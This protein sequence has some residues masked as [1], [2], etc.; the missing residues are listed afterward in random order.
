VLATSV[1]NA[2]HCVFADAAG[3]V[4]ICD[5]ND[6]RLLRETPASGGT[7]SESV[8]DAKL[9][10]PS[11]IAEDA[12]GNLYVADTNNKLIFKETLS[13]ST[14]TQST[15]ATGALWYPTSVA[16]DSS[17]NLY[18]GNVGMN[19]LLKET[20]AGR[21]YT[22]TVIA[23]TGLNYPDSVVLDST[24]AL[25]IVDTYNHRVVRQQLYGDELGA[26][27]VGSTATGLVSSMV[28]TFDSGGS[29][30]ATP[31]VTR[32][33]LAGSDFAMLPSTTCVA[34][35]S[36]NTGDSCTVDV[37]FTPTIAGSVNGS[38]VIQG[39]SG[40]VIATGYVHGTGVAPQVSFSP[41]VES[42][43]GSGFKNPRAVAA[44]ASGNVYIADTDNQRIVKETIA[45]GVYTQSVVSTSALQ[46]P[47]GVAVDGSGNVYVSDTYH[48]REL[49]ETI[50]PCAHGAT[51]VTT[52]SVI[53]SK[54]LN[55]P[56]GIAVD[57]AGVFY[58]A[59]S[60]NN[61]VL[62]ET[63][64][65]SG[66]VA[67][68]LSFQGLTNLYGIAVDGAGNLYL[69]DSGNNRI[70]KETYAGGSYTQSVIPTSTLAFPR[71]VAVDANGD[72]FIADTN[73]GR[74]IEEALLNGS[75][76]ESVV[77]SGL[78]SPDS[79]A[80][81]GSGNLYITDTA[82]NAVL[83][84]TFAAPPALQF[85][86][87]AVGSASPLQMVTLTNVGNAPLSFPAPSAGTNPAL[88]QG[89]TFDATQTNSCPSTSAGHD[90][91]A[92]LPAGQSCVLALG[93]APTTAADGQG[94]AVLSDTNLNVPGG[95]QTIP[96]TGT[97][98]AD[99]VQLLLQV[100]ASVTY[101]DAVQVVAQLTN[102]SSTDS[103]A[104]SVLF[105]DQTASFGTQTVAH[106]QAAQSYLASSVGQV[107]LNASFT[108]QD[109]TLN[110][111]KGNATLTVLAAPLNVAATDASRTYGG[112]NPAFAGTVSGAVNGDSFKESF[113]TSATT[114]S[115]VA[116]YAITPSVSGTGLANYQQTIQA[117]TL[118]VTAAS[119][120]VI[121]NNALRSYGAANPNFTGSVQGAVN[122]DTFTETFT[123]PATASSA[124][125]S[126]AIAPTAVGPSLANYTQTPQNGTLTVAAA[127]LTASANDATRAYGASNP[128]FT[129]AVTGAVNGDVLTESF[130]TTAAAS[131]P[132]GSY[133]IVP[134]VGGAAIGNYTPVLKNG[135]LTVT[136]AALRVVANNTVRSYGATNPTFTGSVQGAVNGDTFTE[137]FT[138]PA[139]ATSAPGSYAIAPAAVGPALANYTQSTE[140]GTLTVKAAALTASA[141]DVTRAYGAAN[142]VFTGAVSGA[143]NGDVV[144]ESFTTTAAASSPAGSY[145]IV[146]AISGAAAGNYT[147]VLK[148]GT[149]TV[150]GAAL[151]ASANDVTRAYGA[152]NPAFTGAVT[153]AVNGDV[154]TESFRTTAAVSSPAGSYAIVPAV[155][156]AAIGNYTPV[157]KNGALT[158]TAAALTA[159]A[160]DVTRAYGAANPVFTGA[161]TGAM[162]GDVLTE[163]FSTSA[164]T[165]SP[166]GSYAIVPAL[167]GAAAGNYTPVLK[168]GTLTVTAAAL[169][170]SAHDA[171]RAYGAV[172]PVFTGA[173]TGA[174]NGEVFTESFTTT[175]NAQSAP[176][177]YGITPVAAGAGL[178]NY[179]QTVVPGTLTITPAALTVSAVNQTLAYGQANPVF[180]G[181]VSGAAAP[182]SFT[183][184]FATERTAGSPVGRYAIVPTAVGPALGVYAVTVQPGQITVTP[185]ALTVAANSVSRSYGAANPV[186]TGQVQGVVNG[187][188][189]TATYTT[190]ATA[191][192][193]AGSYPIH[194]VVTG[195]ALGNYTVAAVDGVLSVNAVS[196]TTALTQPQGGAGTAGP[197]TLQAGV[198]PSAGETVTPTGNVRFYQG[199]TMLAEVPLV[200]GAAS[201][202]GTLPDVQTASSLTAVYQGDGNCLPSS[203]NAIEESVNTAGFWMKL[204][205]A[206]V[207][208][209]QAASTSASVQT[210]FPLQVGPGASGV[211][212]GVVTFSVQ[213]LPAGA[214]ATFSP[215]TLQANSG[216]QNVSMQVT[217]PETATAT[218]A[219]SGLDSGL[220]TNPTRG[221]GGGSAASRLGGAVLAL[222]LLPLAG[223][224]RLRAAGRGMK[225]VCL[226]LAGCAAVAGLTGCG[227]VMGP[228]MKVN[229]A[230]QTVSYH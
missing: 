81:D 94:Y 39:S 153:G 29:L 91:G 127:S 18:I 47:L 148:N 176:G 193:P 22:Q 8:V 59:D 33:G 209:A 115:P 174:V 166:A 207:Q 181:Q 123:T 204:H 30:A 177:S 169:T 92:D 122:G 173:V 118:H 78:G 223:A 84:E 86:S 96:L 112:V 131:S 230:T 21:K 99:A 132:A 82:N 219:D 36:F 104:G 31:V 37:S 79:L 53:V 61:R 175:A 57:G 19:N 4:F 185:A 102:T 200:Q 113:S 40:G 197:V 217:M 69:A 66:Y 221:S 103:I 87:T 208:P 9:W 218:V 178:A 28:F 51:G 129:G 32:Q 80:L 157:L 49:K 191:Q 182:D 136:A 24:G 41:V 168:N 16:V 137:T 172:N 50:S 67:T 189:L 23:S 135:A 158:V 42:V 215:A 119:L 75:Y 93:F 164:S 17:G 58:L 26:V 187:D 71:A 161:V 88:S 124:V 171:T 146:P 55:Y 90:P 202:S 167:S 155:S 60:E 101:G 5:T 203:S 227:V 163:S 229:S 10:C 73:N 7:Y 48:S 141:N 98:T 72:L 206:A 105:A 170:V 198:A 15:V 117:G 222:V 107:S 12:A 63:P 126:Y 142:P 226:L 196:T 144:T 205:G 228:G 97:A 14:Y 180:T 38:A 68:S 125:G 95:L 85:P 89:F 156:G 151:T 186:L 121:A 224:R 145:S 150:T 44:D 108:P 25:L 6:G 212:P 110:S 140:N 138:T 225:L 213:G 70:V 43:V 109:S 133:A 130:T 76:T 54:G 35:Q 149:L 183:E 139:T 184:T 192:S 165:A 152:A 52:E 56:A 210:V 3:N 62:V 162:N 13:G 106:G 134:A 11:G 1:L 190:T 179:T 128:A 214:T 77:R 65:G 216:I 83:K 34:G 45:G 154:L 201:W 120:S 64:S 160:N 2:P 27:A 188:S 116:S 74:V 220:G 147:P 46:S 143:V 211:F 20:L 199:K 195:G 100:P 111:A 159:S 194:G 114:A